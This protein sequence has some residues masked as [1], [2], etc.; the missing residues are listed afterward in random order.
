MI[1]KT[2]IRRRPI[3]I[4]EPERFMSCEE[5]KR[6][7]DLFAQQITGADPDG[8]MAE[9]YT[10]KVLMPPCGFRLRIEYGE[11]TEITERGTAEE[12]GRGAAEEP[13]GMM[14]RMPIMEKRERDPAQR[15]PVRDIS[16]IPAI[17]TD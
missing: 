16:R 7:A 11:E 2:I 8:M 10:P 13:E 14:V 12:P 4:L 5:Q 17:K 3:F 6:E 1:K 15:V 9:D